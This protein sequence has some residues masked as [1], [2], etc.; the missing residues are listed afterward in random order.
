M[1]IQNSIILKF[2]KS[3]NNEILK[4]KIL[5]SQTGF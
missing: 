5:F 4:N 1:L 2:F 3:Y